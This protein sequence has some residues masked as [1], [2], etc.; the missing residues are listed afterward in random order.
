MKPVTL[1]K[2]SFSGRVADMPADG[3]SD[4]RAQAARAFVEAGF[5]TELHAVTNAASDC[6]EDRG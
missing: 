2:E 5:P 6:E 1:D 3:L 4:I